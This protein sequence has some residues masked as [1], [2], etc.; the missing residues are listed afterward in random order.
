MTMSMFSLFENEIKFKLIQS[1]HY[2]YCFNVRR[3]EDPAEEKPADESPR[4]DDESVCMKTTEKLF[5]CGLFLLY[6]L[7]CYRSRNTLLTYVAETNI[8]TQI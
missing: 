7:Y 2:Y 5:S 4:F 3:S 6:H 1:N 8:M